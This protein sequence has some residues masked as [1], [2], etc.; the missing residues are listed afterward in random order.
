M[1]SSYF[2]TAGGGTEIFLADE[3]K[4]ISARHSGDLQS[5]RCSSSQLQVEGKVLFTFSGHPAE[6]LNLKTAERVF[7]Q[8][9]Y[10]PHWIKQNGK[11]SSIMTALQNTLEAI[12]PQDWDNAKHT[13]NFVN[14]PKKRSA[15]FQNN[16]KSSEKLCNKRQ[17]TENDDVTFRVSLKC[18]RE[19]NN[20]RVSS[21]VG[22][23]ITRQTGWK[24]DLRKPLFEVYIQLN[25][26]HLIIGIPLTKIPLSDRPYIETIGLRST[27]A[28][29][30][31]H[32]AQ[33][34]AGDT[35]LDPMCGVGTILIEAANSWKSAKF[36]PQN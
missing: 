10:K 9:C 21:M 31:A 14:P 3:L 22:G 25:N 16:Q 8:L 28:W 26:N 32:K 15:R 5:E 34:Q 17:K 1:E 30:M 18:P 27:V 36:S 4:F 33:I 23:C 7:V 13:W 24:V 19:Y 35:V 11:D 29:I 2:C 12:T 6:L 20:R